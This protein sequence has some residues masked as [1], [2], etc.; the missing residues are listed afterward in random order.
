[1]LSVHLINTNQFIG[2]STKKLMKIPSYVFVGLLIMSLLSLYSVQS[3]TPRV[4][5]VTISGFQYNP[6]PIIVE[7]GETVTFEVSN[8]DS[9]AH[10]FTVN[11]DTLLDLPGGSSN[12]V[13]YTAPMSEQVLPI[14]CDYHSSMK[15]DLKI[16]ASSTTATTSS[17]STTA[18]T[19]TSDTTSS[20]STTSSSG[21]DAPFPLTFFLIGLSLIILIRKRSLFL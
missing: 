19:S 10:T 14:T 12:S 17:A 20:A 8:K 2:Y 1:M 5:T 18:T 9:A 7:P 4:I 21:S 11:G 3:D 6:N 16:Q 15:A 13:N